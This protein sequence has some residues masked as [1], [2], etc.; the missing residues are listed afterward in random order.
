[1]TVWSHHSTI[2]NR[3]FI[4]RIAVILALC[5][6]ISTTLFFGIMARA[7][8]G[9]NQTIGF[10]GRLLDANGNVVP[11]GFYNMQFK[12]YQDGLGV[13]ANNPGGQ[14]RWTE[15][16]I[17]NGGN[18]GVEVKNGY[19]S[20]NLGS[21]H[22]FGNE[23]DWNQDT[24]WLSMNIA[25]K[26]T[27]CTTFST[28]SCADDGEMLPM[29]RMTTSPYAMNAGKVGGKTANDF[30]QL[31]QGAQV[32]A[33]ISTSSIFINKTA[34]GNFVRL[35]NN[36]NDVLSITDSGTISFG[37]AGD[38]T[39]SVA[40]AGTDT[41]GGTI[42]IAGGNGGT[43]SGA[44]GGDIIIKGGNAGGT[45]GNGGDII[46]S[47]GTGNGTG[48]QG[49]VVLTTPTFST[50][51][52][53]EN[54]YTGGAVVATSCTIAST[55]VN[56]SAG[57]MV[58]FSATDQVA[59]L[60]DPIIKTAGRV[61]YVMAAPDSEILTLSV[62]GGGAGNEITLKPN[63]TATMVW[64]GS[65]WTASG[66]TTT[67][68]VD[69][70]SDN[71][72]IQIGDGIDNETTTVLTLDKSGEAPDVTDSNAML[73]SMYYDTTLGKVQCYEADGWGSCSSSPDTFVTLSPEYA[74][75]VTNGSDLGEFKSDICSST[76]GINDGSSAQP[77][78][79][80]TDETYNFYSW[81]SDSLTPETKSVY[82]TYQL[83]DNF[84]KFVSGST[85][86]MGRVSD[87]GHASVNYEVFKN[88]GAGL[89]ACGAAQ[90]VTAVST[91][92]KVTAT[93][94]ADPASV[95]CDFAAGDSLVFKINL[96]ADSDASAYISTLGFAFSDD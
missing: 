21:K 94:N 12:I 17:N 23:V 38:K 13:Q 91:W 80:D 55:S 24:L 39:I 66:A 49:L 83:P 14:L 33:T 26:A 6:A 28:G 73:G 64:N 75:A 57:I 61:V 69:Y 52:D 30:V 62:N 92:E 70:S 35:Q 90:S 65:R 27:D 48:T 53:D 77:L 82:V 20:V 95:A 29:K 15:T 42:T 87:A 2:F 32:D 74:N 96:T 93:G 11:D 16:Y 41:A 58:G 50:V 37:T 43:G 67:K 68:S 44:D 10:Q 60:P 18:N 85:S 71:T 9:I 40:A 81:T 54:C 4:L 89:V 88:A 79:C 8:A 3:Q 72:T 56:N 5:V 45:N 7:Q 59:T 19:L 31:G 63:T 78:V 1:M 76:L 86:L 47:G 36:G 51:I 25:G 22:P 84:K 34:P 46:L